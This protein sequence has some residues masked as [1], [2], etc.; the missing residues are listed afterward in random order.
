M[1]DDDNLVAVD[2]A[3]APLPSSRYYATHLYDL[4]PSQHEHDTTIGAGVFDTNHLFPPLSPHNDNLFDHSFDI[5]FDRMEAR[6]VQPI[7]P[8]EF[9]KGFG[10]SDQL[11]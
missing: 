1:S 2:P 7:S 4:L 5:E 3:A 6:R 8:Y 10:Y 11:T 9:A